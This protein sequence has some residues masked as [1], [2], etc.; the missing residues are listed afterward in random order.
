MAIEAIKQEDSG[1][2]ICLISPHLIEVLNLTYESEV[3][4]EEFFSL[5]K[6]VKACVLNLSMKAFEHQKNL[7]FIGQKL[8][9]LIGS[10]MKTPF[11]VKKYMKNIRQINQYLSEL[12]N[13]WYSR[14]SQA[15]FIFEAENF[16]GGDYDHTVVHYSERGLMKVGEFLSKVCRVIPDCNDRSCKLEPKE[17]E[18]NSQNGSSATELK[19]TNQ[20][21]SSKNHSPTDPLSS[22]PNISIV[23]KTEHATNTSTSVITTTTTTIVTRKRSSSDS[24]NSKS[25]HESGMSNCSNAKKRKKSD[26]S[27]AADS[28]E[29]EGDEGGEPSRRS[30][31]VAAEGEK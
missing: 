5:K 28:I 6:K 9:Y 21:D 29:E 19:A 18:I 26:A 31:R 22:L 13:C 24:N 12:D 10:P 14:Q 25:S 2:Y 16:E 8:H 3:L 30:R 23:T 20:P 11:Y 7:V 27:F 1:K 4:D 15:V 17:S